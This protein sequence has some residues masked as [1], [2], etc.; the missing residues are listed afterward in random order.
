[1]GV[2]LCLSSHLS[3]WAQ[4]YDPGS[5]PP[6]PYL[7]NKITVKA[8]PAEA[9]SW[10]RGQGYYKEG[11]SVN[12]SSSRKSAGYVF[13]HWEKDGVWFSDVQSP[14]FTADNDAHTFTVHYTYSP[15]SPDEPALNDNRLYLTAEPLTACSF[16]KESGLSFVYGQTVS[17]RAYANSGYSF[18]GW[19][20]DGVKQSESL[21]FSFN[22]PEGDV[23]LTARFEYN[24]SNP[25]EPEGDGSQTNVQTTP[26]GDADGDGVVDVADAVRIINLCLSNEFD[27]KADVDADGVVDVAD[28]VAVINICMKAK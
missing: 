13:S 17:L 2:L 27:A 16:N 28:A 21:S 4:D 22:M 5:N 18:L 6:E 12:L 11:A 20:K 10:L 1:M 25:V 24:P 14:T 3:M 9:V 8:E 26:T 19:Y 15:A 23:R 7:Y